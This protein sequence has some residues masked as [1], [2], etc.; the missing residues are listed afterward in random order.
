MS[1]ADAAALV[2]RI[3]A[4]DSEALGELYRHG[5]ERVERYVARRMVE[6][7]D[8]EDVVQETFLRVPEMTREFNPDT[9]EVGAWLCGKVARHTLTDYGRKDRFRRLSAQEA[10]G[11]AL[12]EAVHLGPAQDAHEREA[13]P[14]SPRM[15]HALA[16]LSPAQRR[17]MQ[18]RYLDEMTT[19]QAAEVAGSS[20]GAIVQN[21]LSARKKLR[22]ELAD[23]APVSTSVLDGMSKKDAVLTALRTTDNDMPAALAWLREQGITVDE[24]YAYGIRNGSRVAA[25][26]IETAPRSDAEIAAAE[27]EFARASASRRATKR[28][29]ACAAARVHD[30]RHGRLPSPDE[31]M[32]L[33][34]GL[35]RTTAIVGLRNARQ[36]LAAADG[37]TTAPQ[38]PR[39]HRGSG[40]ELPAV[41]KTDQERQPKRGQAYQA[42]QQYWRDHRELPTVDELTEHSGISRGT[43]GNVLAEIRA[44]MTE[45]P[46]APGIP[47]PRAA[48]PEQPVEDRAATALAVSRRQTDAAL[49]AAA[50]AVQQLRAAPEAC[51]EEA[52]RERS[53]QVAS[54]QADEAAAAGRD[55]LEL[56]S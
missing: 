4:G 24:S 12:S 6:Q 18:L 2:S 48:E 20:A 5:R 27:K 55:A 3:Q 29:V 54:W 7:T 36:Q 45:T 28:E 38:A 33:V 47:A 30:A 1:E 35:S 53:Q 37:D 10:A 46:E 49:T 13:T 41:A 32:G 42:A 50:S 43:C 11:R 21:C 9:H 26:P 19:E 31:L 17:G 34:E 44:A 16:K 25:A 39:D 51:A 8:V 56:A 22:A 14:L 23:L 40:A 52:E 15:V